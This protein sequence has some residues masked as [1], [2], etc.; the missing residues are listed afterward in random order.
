METVQTVKQHTK[1]PH[2]QITK[3]YKMVSS[4]DTPYSNNL[5]AK[6]TDL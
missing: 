5:S 6:M 1:K 3:T 2:R 4:E